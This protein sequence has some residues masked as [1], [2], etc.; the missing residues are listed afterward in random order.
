MTHKTLKQRIPI[1]TLL[2]AATVLA[3]ALTVPGILGRLSYAREAGQ[4]LDARSELLGVQDLSRGFTTVARAL[5][6]SVVHIAVEKSVPRQHGQ[7]PGNPDSFGLFRSPLR[8]FFGERGWRFERRTPQE[9][10]PRPR[11]TSGLG[12]GVII[13]E[14]G[15]IVTNNHVV[16]GA[17]RVFVKL[18]DGREFKGKV[19]GTD[20][21]TDVALVKIDAEG[22]VA[23]QF[24][25][26]ENAE[27]GEWVLAFGSPFGLAATVTSGIISATGRHDLR[28]T[29]Y[30]DFIQTDAAINPGNSGGPLVNTRGEVIGI[31]TAIATR[32][33]QNAGVG[34]AIPINMV[35]RITDQLLEGGVVSRGWLGVAI[36]DYTEALAR[37]VG[38]KSGGVLVSDALDGSPAE[39]AGIQPADVLLRW[40]DESLRDSNHLRHVVAQT[41]P[42]SK[43]EVTL[44]RGSAEKTLTVAVGTREGKGKVSPTLKSQDD[45]G[46]TLQKLT[47]QQLAELDDSLDAAVTVREV[48]PDGLAAKAGLRPGDTILKVGTT[49]V[50]SVAAFRE[51]LLESDLERGVR[52]WILR[53]GVRHFVVVAHRN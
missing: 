32:I 40:G 14:D 16:S 36:Q 13:R 47:P 39:A 28:L 4:A 26:S 37:P 1:T 5:R 23:A 51:A 12:T 35:R 53:D 24:G 29:D 44:R 15:H 2:I 31:N 48:D 50:G 21:E 34:F 17:D 11:H 38:D 22:L 30:E 41:A 20:P 19:I 52:L 7:V 3:A 33:G 42:D 45:L 9:R 46:L 8:D 25:N 6:P 43:V 27:V 18:S 10:Q 49:A